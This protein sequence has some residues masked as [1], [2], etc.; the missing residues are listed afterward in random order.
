MKILF[1]SATYPIPQLPRQGA[2]NRTL[3]EALRTEHDVRVIAPIPWTLGSR[4]SSTSCEQH[5][6]YY[7]PPKILRPH[8]HHFFEWSIQGSVRRLR[9]QFEPEIVLSNW[10]HPDGAA[11]IRI[12]RQMGVPTVIVAGGS[13]QGLQA[14]GASVAWWSRSNRRRDG[15]AACAGASV[16]LST[17]TQQACSFPESAAPAPVRRDARPAAAHPATPRSRPSPPVSR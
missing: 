8:Y 17:V 15:T 12:A 11:S 7:Y 2:Y 16:Q 1:I 9:R 5:P 10:V 14:W 3:V 6:I 4:A 13:D